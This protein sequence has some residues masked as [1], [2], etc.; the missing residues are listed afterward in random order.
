M[1][2]NF[3]EFQKQSVRRASEGDLINYFKYLN[4]EINYNTENVVSTYVYFKE[5]D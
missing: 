4:C 5:E 2:L 3:V 1:R